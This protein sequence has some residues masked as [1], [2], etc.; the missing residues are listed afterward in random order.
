MIYLHYHIYV[1]DRIDETFLSKRRT[2]DLVRKIIVDLN[3]V[4][5]A[6]QL[7]LQNLVGFNIKRPL[8][9]CSR[10]VVIIS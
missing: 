10:W 7:L 1:M 4:G 6:P 9:P 3:F 2:V 8:L 5:S